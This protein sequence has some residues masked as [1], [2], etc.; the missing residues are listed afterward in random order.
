MWWAWAG[1]D[2]RHAPDRERGEVFGPALSITE[3]LGL[4]G[5]LAEAT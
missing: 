5:S 1:N 4:T 2:K 3:S